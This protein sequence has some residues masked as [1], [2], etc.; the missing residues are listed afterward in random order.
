MN[1][2]Q[3][4]CLNIE[5]PAMRQHRE[6]QNAKRTRRARVAEIGDTQYAPAKENLSYPIRYRPS[7]L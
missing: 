1:P 2:Q 5:C 6:T 3:V 4:L 7:T